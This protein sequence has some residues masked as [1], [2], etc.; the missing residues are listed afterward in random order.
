MDKPIYGRQLIRFAETVPSG[1]VG[2]A[3]LPAHRVVGFDLDASGDPLTAQ[4]EASGANY[5]TLGVNQFTIPAST[6]DGP[7]VGP[8]N[9]SVA[10]S[11]LLLVEIDTTDVPVAGAALKVIAGGK[12]S[13][14]AGAFAVTVNGT[15]P[16]IREV[17]GDFAIVSFS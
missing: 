4:G 3:E 1:Q 17:Y 5:A 15:T 10:T 13:S 11:G 16:T 14:A 6:D 2:T 9:A 8:R 12:A 7:A